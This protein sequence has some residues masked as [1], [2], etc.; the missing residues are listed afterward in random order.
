[1]ESNVCSH[2]KV[3]VRVRPTNSNEKSDNYR[4]VV[5]VVDKHMLIFDPK[6]ED[7]SCFGSRRVRNRNINKRPNKDLKFVFDQVFGEN[8]TQDEIFENAMKGVL[9]GIMNGFNCTVFAYGATGAGKTHTMLGT[10]DEPGVMYRTM[11]DL[12]KRMDDAK[13]EKEF[14]VAV[15][16]LEVYNEQIRDLL[17]NA[18]PLAVREDSGKGVVVQGLTL[19]QPKSAES[20]LQ[21]LDFG[22]RNR[23]Q[24]PTDMNATSSRSHAVFQIYLRQQ[25][26]AASL[27][28]NVCVAKMSLIDL[29]GSERASAANTKGQRLREGANINRSLLALGNVINA[30]A[31]PKSKKAHIPYRDSKLTR[32]LKDSLGG[33]CSTVMIAN[34][35][36]SSKSYDDTQNTLKY[37][38]R[39]KEIKSSL[40][41][42]VI[43][44]DSHI[45]QYAVICEKQRQ[46]IVQLKQKLKEYEGKDLVDKISTEKQADIKRVS[47]S[48][49]QVFSNRAQIRREQ[50]DLERQLKENELRQRYSEEDN[51]QIQY[52]SAN[53]K[54]EK[55]TCKH[56]R[57]LG[58]LR[59]EQ[60][61]IRK[62]LKEAEINFQ[63]NDGWLHRV[64]NEVKSFK[65]NN[66]ISEILE[67]D[68]RCHRLELQVND[69]KQ[70]IKQMVKIAALQDQENKRMQKMVNLLL[71]A[72]GQFYSAMYD[73]GLVTAQD[74][75]KNQELMQILLRERSVAWADQVG[76]NQDVQCGKSSQESKEFGGEITPF[77]A[78]S[79]L[80]YFQ[81]SPCSAEGRAKSLIKN[82]PLS[83]GSRSH[84]NLQQD[85]L[86][87]RAVRRNL[88]VLLPQQSP[89]TFSHE[90]EEGT[91][92]LQCTPEPAQKDVKFSLSTRMEPNVT[93]EVQ[94]EDNATIIISDDDPSQ[95]MKSQGYSTQ[96]PL[97][98]PVNEAQQIPNKRHQLSLQEKR[99][100]NP[101]YMGM[102]SAAQG[103]RKHI[104]ENDE[105]LSA[106]KRVKKALSIS[107]RPKRGPPPNFFGSVEDKP[108]RAV[109]SISEGNPN[110]LIPSKRSDGNLNAFIP[111]KPK[112]HLFSQVTKWI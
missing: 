69:L 14:S 33:N 5:Q 40:K 31:N 81:S 108:Q 55:A 47:E 11:E 6:E 27:N 64:E 52:I 112:S 101:A 43:S 29:A 100:A 15:S 22:N 109:R 105:N 95:E 61:R 90:F 72:Y 35:S 60:E 99:R 2:V 36:P 24:H 73:S 18:G 58:M 94:H 4:N 63:K 25:D 82:A 93:L 103:K 75:L 44:L 89:K 104:R 65:S 45:G 70:H 91:F 106:P 13:E 3:V 10:P 78:F 98:N 87:R 102:T 53:E 26:K 67:K 41:S 111:S 74:E 49:Q 71:P 21:A 59:S 80:L 48:L 84:P 16:Y 12:F 88:A 96:T 42:N 37:A 86:P 107:T 54:T 68:V 92:P 19:H 110:F 7:F 97:I 50:L 51:L 8:S 9:D 76:A 34:I 66:Q 77:L 1:M 79:K 39:A 57:R 32:I 46:E 30:L 85:I 20:I 62:K 83:K 28:P 56:E 38:N 17:A 23:T